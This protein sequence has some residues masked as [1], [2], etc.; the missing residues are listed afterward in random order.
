M[1][2]LL[3][4]LHHY[5]YLFLFHYRVM[6]LRPLLPVQVMWM[7]HHSNTHFIHMGCVWCVGL[8]SIPDRTVHNEC[9][10]CS[11]ISVINWATWWCTAR[12]LGVITVAATVIARR[13]ATVSHTA[14]TAHTADT[15]RWSVRCGLKDGCVISVMNLVMRRPI[16]HRD[17]CVEC[18][19]NRVI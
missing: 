4:F 19:I 14:F 18:V 2:F 1:V 7:E 8:I 5:H 6:L 3:L 13:C 16:V 17:S 10:S 15:G 12:W 9:V 11:V